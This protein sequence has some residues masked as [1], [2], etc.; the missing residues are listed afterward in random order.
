M[1]CRAVEGSMIEK[2]MLSAVIS[3]MDRKEA[4]RKTWKNSTVA[5]LTGVQF[6][7]T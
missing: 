1:K 6:I 4:S 3:D 2:G 5:F 7:L